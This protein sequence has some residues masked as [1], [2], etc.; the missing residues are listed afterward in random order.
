MKKSYRKKGILKSL[1][2]LSLG[3]LMT[4]SLA[5]CKG[6]VDPYDGID[7]D[8]TY[9]TLGDNFSVTN[10]D[11]FEELLYGSDTYVARRVQEALVNSYMTEIKEVIETKYGASDNYVT[12]M[13]NVQEYFL[14][15]A[16]SVD[17]LEA[18][19][20]IESESTK[21]VSKF[22]YIDTVFLKGIELSSSE[23]DELCDTDK[24]P[25][26]DFNT[27]TEAQQKVLQQYYF[28]Y[29]EKLF[30]LNALEEEITEFYEDEDND[31][32]DYYTDE[33]LV[34]LWET[35]YLYNQYLYALNIRFISEDELNETLKTFGIKAYKKQLYFLKQEGVMKDGEYVDLTN[36]EYSEWYDDFDFTAITNTSNKIALTDD[37]MVL[38]LYVAIYN[39]IY[40]Y[41]E[42]LPMEDN[43]AAV[44][45]ANNTNNRR[46][47]TEAI[48]AGSGVTVESY[49]EKLKTTSAFTTDRESSE[50]YF[51]Y[52]GEKME[53]ISA[54][55]KT[56]LYETYSTED[57]EQRYDYEGTSYGSYYYLTYKISEAEELTDD[58]LVYDEDDNSIDR[59]A[60]EGI[61]NKLIELKKDEDLTDTYIASALEDALENDAKVLVY[62]DIMEIVYSASTSGSFYSTTRKKSPENGVLASI[63]YN[64]V[65]TYIYASEV[66]EALEPDTG[67][68]SAIDLL[69]T[70]VI[71]TT[72]AYKAITE[73]EKSE[74]YDAIT[75][76]LTSF[77]N[78]GLESSGYAADLGKYNFLMLYFHTADINEIVENYFMVNEASATLI[79]NYNSDSLVNLMQTYTKTSYESYFSISASNLLIYVDFDEDSTPDEDFDWDTTIPG[80][81]ETTYAELANELMTFIINI[82]ENSSD[83]HAT[84]LADIVEDFNASS[85]FTNGH[86]TEKVDDEYDPTETDS[87]YAKYRRA[88]LSIKIDEYSSV[89]N[90]TAITSIP[91]EL[92]ERLIELYSEVIIGDN[93]PSEY[94]D[95]ESY[96]SG[97]GFS[98]KYGY[99]MLLVTGATTKVSAE[100]TSDDD[101]NGIYTELVYK[102]G[103]EFYKVADLYSDTETLSANQIKGYLLEYVQ[104]GTT[105][106]IP[107]SVLSAITSYLTPVYTRYTDSGTQR[108]VLLAWL[109]KT[110]NATVTFTENSVSTASLERLNEIFEINRRSA[111]D[112]NVESIEGVTNPGYDASINQ[113]PGWWDAIDEYINNLE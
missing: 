3:A 40:T 66:W 42:Q 9:A 83:T 30:G 63:E 77:A 37:A 23:F 81:S 41:R 74:Y 60:Y 61:V 15:D 22:T 36:Q 112:Y 52:N 89:T 93:V 27:L 99:N 53:L 67:M 34:T 113:Y 72:D 1:S 16:F 107:S 87:Y 10:Q 65:T 20:D 49:F 70:Q 35:E 44:F 98:N 101:K 48:I 12:Y 109:N 78:G 71:K 4:F 8:A 28:N 68:T 21:Y 91:I 102:Y 105:N 59:E 57:G 31:G 108:A 79:N 75:N 103:D 64:D 26:T 92:K 85:R 104:D 46:D 97:D 82:T 14:C 58:N 43:V 86:D 96:K 19:L 32:T 24:L 6:A 56:K 18:Y 94:L 69:S 76:L 80:D 110:A 39:Y 90:S 29:A 25:T 111:D 88:G 84:V 55:L 95:A 2:L 62:D 47:V 54:N 17:D 51:A 11:V 5:S 100:F 73:D 106:T 7:K 45:N 33:E 50:N 13:Q 38:E